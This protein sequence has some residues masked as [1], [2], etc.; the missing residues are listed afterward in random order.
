MHLPYKA[1]NPRSVRGAKKR[2]W[3]IVRARNG[4]SHDLSWFGLVLW[5]EK[6][7]SGYWVA[8]CLKRA[9][10]VDLHSTMRVLHARGTTRCEG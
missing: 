10:F 1:T 4:Y 2:G 5:C 3:T 7:M 6:Q 9:Q 8:A